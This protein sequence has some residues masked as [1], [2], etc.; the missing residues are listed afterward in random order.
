[1]NSFK[2]CNIVRVHGLDAEP[3]PDTTAMGSHREKIGLTTAGQ[4]TGRK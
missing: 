4:E 1:M 2:D 3:G